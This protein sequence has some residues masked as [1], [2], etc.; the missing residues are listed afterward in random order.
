MVVDKGRYKNCYVYT[1]GTYFRRNKVTSVLFGISNSL[2][3]SSVHLIPS[4]LSTMAFT[5]DFTF[6]FSASGRMATELHDRRRWVTCARLLFRL[7]G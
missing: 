2:L 6:S 7:F 5:A 4:P 1:F 3:A